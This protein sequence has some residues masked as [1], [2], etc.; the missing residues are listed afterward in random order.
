MPEAAKM[1]EPVLVDPGQPKKGNAAPAAKAK[2]GAFTP[3]GVSP[4]RRA[5]R[6]YTIRLWAVR[7]SRF[8][9]WFY[10]NFAS[11]FLFLHPVWKKLGYNRVEKP[12]TFVERNVK[13]L[14]ETAAQ[15]P[16]RWRA[17]QW[18]LRGRAGHAL[19]LGSGLERLAQHGIR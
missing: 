15:R 2:T 6:S 18:Q 16:L 1:A 11:A 19:R 3:A 17:R 10:R 4:N 8:L 12:I 7:N 13:G 14:S 9:E 5:R